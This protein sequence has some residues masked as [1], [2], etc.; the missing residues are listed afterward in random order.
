MHGLHAPGRRPELR[1]VALCV[2]GLLLWLLSVP[3]GAQ[4]PR[5]GGTL[6]FIVSAEPPSF[7]TH[8]EV[9]FA[10]IHPARPHYNLLVTFAPPNYPKPVPDLAASWTI[11]PDATTNTVKIRR[12][13]RFHDC[14][15]LSS[16]GI[17]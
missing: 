5:T 16:R 8:R 6:T 12:G 14:N 4:Q 2:T 1:I 9:T 3:L 15:V 10:L 7:D 11:S 13:V 17:Q